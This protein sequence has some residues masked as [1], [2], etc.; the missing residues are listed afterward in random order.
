MNQEIKEIL[1]AY[2][3]ALCRK[4]YTFWKASYE[5]VV[6]KMDI[7]EWEKITGEKCLW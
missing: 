1:D 5:D 4:K 7:A 6:T 3:D 2:R